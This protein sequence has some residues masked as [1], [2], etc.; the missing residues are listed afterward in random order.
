MCL[1][2][3]GAIATSS[4]CLKI[5]IVW[6]APA[7][8]PPAVPYSIIRPIITGLASAKELENI[9]T[10]LDSAVDNHGHARSNHVYNV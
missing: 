6:L 9:A 7:I 8:P 5:P 2:P 3:L 1:Q 10:S 4:S